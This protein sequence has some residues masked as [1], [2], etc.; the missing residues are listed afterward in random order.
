M[1]KIFLS[2]LLFILATTLYSQNLII[3][4]SF[5]NIEDS[6]IQ[7]HFSADPLTSEKDEFITTID[8]NGNFHFEYGINAPVKISFQIGNKNDLIAYFFAFPNSNISI[9]ADCQNFKESLDF[10]GKKQK[11]TK[12][13]DQLFSEHFVPDTSY[14]NATYHDW[15]IFK[16][17]LNISIREKLVLLDSLYKKYSL[18]EIEYNYAWAEIYYSFFDSYMVYTWQLRIPESSKIYSFFD[19]LD[20]NNGAISIL[21]NSYNSYVEYALLHKYKRQ[22][23]LLEERTIPDSSF[24]YNQYEY[25]KIHLIDTVRDVFLTRLLHR[26]L[27]TGIPGADQLY[28]QY[29]ND[30]KTKQF[31]NLIKKDYDVFLLT[32]IKSE[33]TNY[34]IITKPENELSDFLLKYKGK[35]LLLEFWGSWCSPCIKSIPKIKAINKKFDPKKFQVIHIAVGDKYKLMKFAIKKYDIEGVNILLP[36]STELRWKKE[37]NFYTV[38]YYAIINQ[39]SKI[40]EDGPLDILNTINLTNKI[41]ETI[42]QE[43]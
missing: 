5:Q 23:N 25:G 18:S 35:V 30:C 39:N 38:P 10:N 31:K 41:K 1:T 4:G 32:K 6:T 8:D 33:N 24:Y 21:N 28:L 43:K 16:D 9:S 20:L 26:V 27:S 3:S 17:K 42:N 37:I 2:F 15:N 13:K 12:I 7:F 14:F 36:Q 19:L 34:V 40:V 22:N 11:L 29:Q